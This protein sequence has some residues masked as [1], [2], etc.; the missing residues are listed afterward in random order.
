MLKLT[1][2]LLDETKIMTHSISMI[3]T[4]N[5]NVKLI[6]KEIAE[7]EIDSVIQEIELSML[8][9]PPEYEGSSD[10]ESNLSLESLKQEISNSV[11]LDSS[12]E[13]ND[14]IDNQGEGED[15][16]EGENNKSRNQDHLHNIS[17]NITLEGQSSN[18]HQ[19]ESYEV[20]DESAF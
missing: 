12:Q 14:E 13:K 20:E 10:H 4:I 5:I 17:E 7:V 15:Q 6:N 1:A 16:G 19:Q 2:K 18:V 11:I 8:N 9:E 3:L